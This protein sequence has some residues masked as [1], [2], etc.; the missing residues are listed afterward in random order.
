MT[1]LYAGL[2][3]VGAGLALFGFARFQRQFSKTAILEK[4]PLAESM[5]FE[6]PEAGRFTISFERPPLA[7]VRLNPGTKSRLPTRSSEQQP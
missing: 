2:A 7:G 5:R 6:V 4:G 1:I 3:A